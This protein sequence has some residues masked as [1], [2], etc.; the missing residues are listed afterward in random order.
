MDFSAALAAELAILAE[1]LD[2]AGSDPATSL[3][4]LTTDLRRAVPS[5]LGLTVLL[6]GIEQPVELTVLPD[7][8]AGI[9]TSV[10]VPLSGPAERRPAVALILYAGTA[11]A[12]VDLA[13]DLAWL[14]GFGLAEFVLDRH[15]AVPLG[16]DGGESLR[17]ISLINQALG[18]L[19]GQGYLPESAHHELE[20]RAALAGTTRLAIADAILA[21]LNPQVPK[22]LDPGS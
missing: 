17:S 22:E 1:A 11:G 18:V 16:R 20:A 7:G 9:V 19:I 4:Q 12:F 21:A 8:V 14:T 13:A 3:N 6:A 2:G 5:Y 10:L 15:L